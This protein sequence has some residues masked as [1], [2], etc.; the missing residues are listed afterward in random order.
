MP[1]GIAVAV[2]A[3]DGGK[4]TS[5]RCLRHGREWLHGPTA[6]PASADRFDAARSC[7]WDE[8]FPTVLA[9]GELRDHGDLWGRPWA[10]RGATLSYEDPGG[11][12]QF[13][14][15]LELDGG[16]ITAAYTLRNVGAEALPWMWAMHPILAVEP[17]D[18][19]ELPGV[20]EVIAEG[21]VVGW[22][23]ATLGGRR[24]R[25]DRIAPADGKTVLKLYARART[26]VVTGER[27]RLTVSSELPYLG[28][29]VNLGG[30]PA[31]GSG[32]HQL[33]LEP[34]TA[35]VDD[36]ATAVTRGLVR[37][38]GPGEET[39]WTATVRVD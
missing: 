9:T 30:W 21:R 37:V 2:D 7:G 10:E 11:R 3:H 29:Y 34:T 31:P 23:V 38:A 18:R 13:E 35:P 14:R 39:R 33:G 1:D 17:G 25:L 15:S 24:V 4:V 5:L 12:Y 6:A 36:L 19:L 22:P 8:L 32:L 26:A 16:T 28:L 20:R 27:C